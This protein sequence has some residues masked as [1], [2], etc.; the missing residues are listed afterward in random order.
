MKK[1]LLTL[2][3]V[4]TLGVVANAQTEMW[5]AS[6]E[7]TYGTNDLI[8][9][10]WANF[11]ELYDQASQSSTTSEWISDFNLFDFGTGDRDILD[12]ILP[13]HGLNTDVNA[14][15]GSGIALLLGL[16]AAYALKKRKEE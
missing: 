8:M 2:T 13:D 3:L 9:F 11:T 7:S 6:T 10:D 14:P 15:L 12:L 4:L 5:E 16:G 1:T